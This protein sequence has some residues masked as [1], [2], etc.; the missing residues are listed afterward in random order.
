MKHIKIFGQILLGLGVLLSLTACPGS[1]GNSGSPQLS[2]LSSS[3]LSFSAKLGQDK[4]GSFSF[5]NSGDASLSFNLSSSQGFLSFSPN[6]GTVGIGETQ[7]INVV[8]SCGQTVGTSNA[9]LILST[10]DSSAPN[11]TLAVSLVCSEASNGKFNIDIQFSG[12]GFTTERQQAFKDAAARWSEVVVG[13]VEDALFKPNVLN[14]NTACGFT[15]ETFIT[16]VDDLIIFANIRLIDGEN[17]ILGQAGPAFLRDAGAGLPIVGCMEFDSADVASLEGKGTFDEVILHEMGHVLGIGTLWDRFNLVAG[18]CNNE[19]GASSFSGSNALTEW[20]ALSGTGNVPIEDDFGDGTACGHWDEGVFDGEL[21]TGF[22]ENQG[23]VPLSRLTI[24]S[25]QD[26][27]YETSFVTAETFSLPD[28]NPNC[29]NT[30]SLG[31][32]EKWEI[33]IRPDMTRQERN[34]WLR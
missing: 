18:K 15:N 24:A 12:D 5:K 22:L 10:N 33:L 9:S 17:G 20:Q 28:C 32:K 31:S 16:E 34:N 6:S 13:D 23:A 29:L 8:A 11:V 26:L 7:T 4:Q 27:G 19:S 14:S 30:N 1:L 25:L 21:M 3:Q 2:D